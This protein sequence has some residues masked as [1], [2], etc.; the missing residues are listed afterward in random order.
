M[1][2]TKEKQ[3]PQ[4]PYFGAKYPDASCT[5]GYLWDLDS[6]DSDAGGC[7]KGGEDPCPFCNESEYVQRLKDSEFSEIEIQAHIEYLNKKY[8][9]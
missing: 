5:D 2:N 6:Y 1:E 7:T 3:C 9:D 4:F 8:N